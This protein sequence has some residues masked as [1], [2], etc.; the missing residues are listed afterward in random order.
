MQL[1]A[2]NR[3]LTQ[4][5]CPYSSSITRLLEG[6]GDGDDDDDDAVAA[7]DGRGVAGGDGKRTRVVW[8]VE[9]AKS[10]DCLAHRS[11]RSSR[12]ARI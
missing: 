6:G 11:A 12:S 3:R 9:F 10:V 4:V 2:G 1:Q 7:R 8:V 5:P